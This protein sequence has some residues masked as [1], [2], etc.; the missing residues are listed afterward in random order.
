[1]KQI[2]IKYWLLIFIFSM[3]YAVYVTDMP[4]TVTQPDGTE[5]NCYS[6]G[7]EFF[8][9]IHDE[10]GYTIIQSDIDGF[11]YFAEK[12]GEVLKP[13]QYLPIFDDPNTKNLEKWAKISETEYR[14]RVQN[15][16]STL[17]DRDAPTSGVVT[18]LNIFIRFND[19]E[20]FS[21]PRSYYDDVYN[22][23][24][25]PSLIDYY[26]EVSY[27]VLE[28]NTPHFP[29]CELDESLSYQDPEPRSYYQPYNP[30]TNPNGYQNDDDRRYR[31][32]TLLKNAIEFIEPEVAE[33]LDIDSDNDGFVDNVSF[34]VYGSPG[35]WASLLWPHRWSLTS[36]DV[37]INDKLVSDYNFNMETGG[38]FTVGTICHEFFHTLGAPDLYHYYDN[39]SPNAVGGWDI[40][41]QSSDPPQY[42]CAFMK[43]KYG[44]WIPEIPEITASGNYFMLPLS[45]PNNNCF[46]FSSPNTDTEYFVVEYRVKE[47]IYEINTP[48][49]DNGLLVYRINT[50]VGNGNADGPPDEVY[51]YRVNGTLTSNGS[52]GQAPFSA[53]VGRTQINDST[54]PSCFLTDGSPGGLSI[55]NIGEA[56]EIIEFNFI[57]L[58]LDAKLSSII[59][60][61]DGDGVPN[62]GENITL[63]IELENFSSDIQA[64]E[65]IGYLSTES[66]VEIPIS[67][68]NFD[69]MSAGETVSASAEVILPESIEL[70]IAEF[71]LQISANF[72]ENGNI[73][74]YEDEIDFS[75]EISL[76]Q[77][78]FPYLTDEQIK[79]SP[80]VVDLD[81]DGDFEIIFGDDSGLVHCINSLGEEMS[82]WPFD[83]YD[84]IWGSPAVADLDEDGDFEIVVSSKSKILFILDQYGNLLTSY[85]SDIDEE[86]Q[87]L[88]GTPSIGNMDD[89]SDLEIVFGGYSNPGWLYAINLDGTDVDG[90]PYELN[91]KI[92]RGIALG[93]F[94]N[95]GK[96]DMV[97]GTDDSNLYFLY[98]DLTIADGFPVN[99]GNDIRSAPSI[100]DIYGNKIICFGSKD[101]SFYAINSD[102]STRFIIPT[103]G[104]VNSSPSFL[105]VNDL[106]TAI[107]FGS[108]DGNLYAVDINGN[109][110]VGWPQNLNDAVSASAVFANLDSDNTP[111]II[112]SNEGN[113][114]YAF[115][116]DGTTVDYF[117]IGEDNT[118]TGSSAVFDTDNDGD[119]EILTGNANGLFSIDVKE[120]GSTENYWNLYR[121]N[122]LRNGYFESQITQNSNDETYF[123]PKGFG[124][125]SIYPN[126]FNPSTTIG[127]TI[128]T[129]ETYRNVSLQIYNLQ[130]QLVETLVNAKL[131]EGYHQVIWNADNQPSGIYFAKLTA[132]GF[133]HN[134]KLLLLK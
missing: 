64:T 71:S 109:S 120:L 85:D 84:E 45:N 123:N 118:F 61:G 82:N 54:N 134:Q 4:I 93:D 52:F 92:Q 86:G 114:L 14:K 17:V 81:E 35:A 112:C 87:W 97:F 15:F 68:I 33:D 57:N 19:E 66:E 106:G 126:P 105:D 83:A 59:D 121:G 70:G 22:K 116:L 49:E 78:G 28:V 18:N 99:V 110:L 10:N 24:E 119:L 67:E 39:T 37:Y 111:E 55:M 9:W 107:F 129:V 130:G 91:E 102:G 127:F 65:I 90:F 1:M 43:W 30:V 89:D 36:Y 53:S 128:P 100:L 96:S 32:H 16:R 56:G 26:D 60:N 29:I 69:D 77:A 75:F 25:G 27:G 108:D 79:T 73:L 3:N 8:N 95:N 46:K 117:P 50:T 74:D 115:N 20:E 125:N 88:M 72:N 21:N 47:G 41:E 76:D 5:I 34:L 101:N 58:F 44:D 124:L 103:G 63:N 113:K 122:L 133:T 62:P 38:Y 2:T 98:D 132:N 94:N 31:E 131:L 40:M 80:A 13:S 11:F 48:G 6:S 51:L 23:I 42:M 104:D 7:D 12:V